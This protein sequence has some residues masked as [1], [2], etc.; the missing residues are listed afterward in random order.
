MKRDG[1]DE[2]CV[3]RSVVSTLAAEPSLEAVTI[4]AANGTISVATLGHA[5]AEKLTQLITNKI[6]AAQQRGACSLLEGSEN[7]FVCETPLSP[8]ERQNIVIKHKGASTTI[9]RATC[10]TAPHFW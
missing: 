5:D 10:P 4:D 3:A 8:S 6:H 1:Q 7:C 9:A 2:V